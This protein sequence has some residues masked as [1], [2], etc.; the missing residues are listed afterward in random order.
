MTVVLKPQAH[1]MYVFPKIGFKRDFN[2]PTSL[3]MMRLKEYKGKQHKK[4]VL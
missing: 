3:N 1:L 2:P 4:C